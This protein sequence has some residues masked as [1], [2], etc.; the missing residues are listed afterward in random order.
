LSTATLFTQALKPARSPWRRHIFARAF[1][2]A[3]NPGS[4][5]RI[6]FVQRRSACC[7]DFVESYLNSKLQAN[8]NLEAIA[9]AARILGCV[10]I[11][12]Q[13]YS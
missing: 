10:A 13:L 7:I 3:P 6:L 4:E 9:A 5:R 12:V 11:L 8:R 2:N 1:E